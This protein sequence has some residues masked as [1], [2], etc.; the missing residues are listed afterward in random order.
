M[1]L[2]NK[3]FET[4]Q[5]L[6]SRI[7]EEILSITKAEKRPKII[8]SGGNSPKMLFKLIS[9][10]LH[11]FDNTTFLMSDERIVDIKNPNSNEGDFLRISNISKEKLISLRDKNLIQKIKHIS[12]YDLSV[13][14]M[15]EDG[16]F[17]SIFPNCINTN[18]ALNSKKRIISFDDN[19]LS[20]MRISLSLH[21]ILKSKKIILIASSL[22][23]QA[24]LNDQI[25]LPIHQLLKK[26]SNKLLIFNCN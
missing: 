10:N 25:E 4:L 12:S 20:F 8:L 7:F 13:L 19:H 5:D 6:N 23:K 26:A 3:R 21:E 16:H 11:Y 17:A 2:I 22:D 24:L 15:G 18:L 1:N 14:G 9:K